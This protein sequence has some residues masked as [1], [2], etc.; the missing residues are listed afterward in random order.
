[1]KNIV[2]MAI[3]TLFSF[4]MVMSQ[5]TYGNQQHMFD[6]AQ[7]VKMRT[8]KMVKEF[9][10]NDQQKAALLELNQTF[11]AKMQELRSSLKKGD[12]GRP[13]KT[14]MQQMRQQMQQNRADY[15][16]K[17]KTILTPEQYQK[18]IDKK[19]SQQKKFN[20]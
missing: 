16:A 12:D 4:N 2:L 20:N 13:D 10:L 8:E 1:M 19:E 7:I 14:Q 17:L 6:P 15:E 3:A 18:Y 5:N 11:E 9:S